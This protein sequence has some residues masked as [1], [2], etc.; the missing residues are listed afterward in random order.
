MKF[1]NFFLEKQWVHAILQ[2]PFEQVEEIMT[3]EYD[4]L[5]IKLSIR[6]Y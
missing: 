5:Q 2:Q 6:V 1:L 4:C 3:M